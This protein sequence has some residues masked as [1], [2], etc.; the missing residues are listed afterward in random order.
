MPI[1]GSIYPITRGI[2]GTIQDLPHPKY[3]YMVNTI[4]SVLKTHR[5]V[6]HVSGHEHTLQLIQDSSRNYIVSGS[7]CKT[8]RVN[9]GK[10]AVFVS[11]NI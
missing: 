9:K 3:Q 11:E 8:S 6:I 10:K 5:N 1:I 7:G 4:T 2:F